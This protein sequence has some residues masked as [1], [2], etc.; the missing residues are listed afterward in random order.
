MVEILTDFVIQCLSK[1]LLNIQNMM[2]GASI[3]ENESAF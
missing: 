3:M 1:D 2:E